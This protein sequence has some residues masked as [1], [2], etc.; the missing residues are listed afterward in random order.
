MTAH[1]ASR[2]SKDQATARLVSAATALL[3]REGPSAL[4]ARSVAAEAGMS[5]SAVY[6]HIGGLPELIQAVVDEGFEDLTTAFAAI[7]PT[8]DPV[9]DL[10]THALAT[11]DFAQ[12]SPHRYDLMFGLSTR[13]TYRSW[14]AKPGATRSAAFRRTYE[15]LFH[16]C[17]RV[18]ESGRL[19]ASTNVAELADQ[20]WC[21]VHGFVTLELGGHLAHRT[22]P[23]TEILE[24]LTVNLLTSFGDS[25]EAALASHDLAL[26]R[27]R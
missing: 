20:L 27:P 9:A 19:R 14:D 1:P 24:P 25:R 13:G 6:H 26:S 17:E 4:K 23:V 18:T 22:S 5:S 3:A 7:D 12:A 2:L 8:S 10:F 16:A 11:R 15:R 21:A